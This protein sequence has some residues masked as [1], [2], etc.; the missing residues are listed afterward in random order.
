MEWLS[1]KYLFREM[2][3]YY[4]VAAGPV[5]KLSLNCIRSLKCLIPEDLRCII[6]ALDLTGQCCA[7]RVLRKWGQEGGGHTGCREAHRGLLPWWPLQHMMLTW[8]FN[9]LGRGRR[10]LVGFFLSLHSYRSDK[11]PPGKIRKICKYFSLDSQ[12]DWVGRVP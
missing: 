5:F 10:A 8:S 11:R 3:F 2:Q 6:T 4:M 7:R 1:T 12:D 9:C